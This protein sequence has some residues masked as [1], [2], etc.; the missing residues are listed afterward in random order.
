M[1]VDT[2][3]KKQVLNNLSKHFVLVAHNQL[4]Q[5]YCSC[6]S[7][8]ETSD[9]NQQN[10][11]PTAP[12][13]YPKN[14]MALVSEGAGGGNIRTFF[15][16]PDGRVINYLAGYWKEEQY[17]RET[18]WSLKQI[19]AIQKSESAQW[20]KDNPLLAE[21]KSEH[22][23]KLD[24]KTTE[25]DEFMSPTEVDALVR[26][27]SPTKSEPEDPPNMERRTENSKNFN[28]LMRFNRLI[29]S[30]REAK[31]FVGRP[32]QSVLQQ[33]EEEVYTKGAVGCGS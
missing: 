25:R 33:V 9:P 26:E 12:K 32:V 19:S 1:R 10:V 18:D 16:M 29:R 20:W 23:R 28:R 31:D 27:L 30:G 21:L 14:Q 2:L 8:A 4:P 17:R 13:Q 22:D 6:Q 5:L 11:D 15:C 3:E 24:Q 7:P